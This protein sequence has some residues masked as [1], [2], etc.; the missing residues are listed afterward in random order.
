MVRKTNLSGC[1][2]G[3]GCTSVRT[4]PRRR[5]PTPELTDWET[6]LSKPFTVHYIHGGL[7]SR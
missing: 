1:P 2:V 3:V 5:G 4:L 7:G 6:E